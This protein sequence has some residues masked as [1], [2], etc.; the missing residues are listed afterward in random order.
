[1]K[2][3]FEER[4]RRMVTSGSSMLLRGGKKGLEKESLRI[5]ADGAPAQLGGPGCRVA[6]VDEQVAVVVEPVAELGEQGA[7][8][9]GQS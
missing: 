6:L 5:T 3:S 2:K 7:H 9:P 4:I 8:G 1:M